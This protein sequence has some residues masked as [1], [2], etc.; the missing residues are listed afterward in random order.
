MGKKNSPKGFFWLMWVLAEMGEENS[1]GILLALKGFVESHGLRP[2]RI[3]EAKI[4]SPGN[5]ADI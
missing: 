3:N 1:K 4:E 5:C 2:I